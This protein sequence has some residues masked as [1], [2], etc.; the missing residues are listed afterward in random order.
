MENW[1]IVTGFKEMPYNHADLWI[2]TDSALKNSAKLPE[3]CKG[4]NP[5]TILFQFT[6][7]KSGKRLDI[8]FK[9][10]GSIRK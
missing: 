5:E 8:L 10:Y 3:H 2:Y 4:F 9:T 1:L 7:E 6:K